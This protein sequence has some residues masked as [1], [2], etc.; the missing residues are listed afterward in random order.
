MFPLPTQSASPVAPAEWG[1]QARASP[2][3]T[4]CAVLLDQTTDG[5]TRAAV[6]VLL[7]LTGSLDSCSAAGAVAVF[8]VVELVL[9]LLLVGLWMP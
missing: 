4:H 6:V 2:T 9:P 1:G 5:P 7:L 8:V 3:R